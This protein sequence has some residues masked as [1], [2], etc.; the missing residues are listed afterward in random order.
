MSSASSS[1][2]IASAAGG[3]AGG[4][5]GAPPAHPEWVGLKWLLGVRG[6]RVSVDR[7]LN[8]PAYAWGCLRDALDSGDPTLSGYAARLVARLE[9][10]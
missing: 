10:R 9:H 6:H 5:A 1:S 2:S 4:S 8:D 7:L 3:F